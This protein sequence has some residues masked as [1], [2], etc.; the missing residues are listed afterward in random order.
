MA[1]ELK[2]LVFT[3][4]LVLVA[5]SVVAET[6]ERSQCLDFRSEIFVQREGAVVTHADVDA[7]LAARVPEEQLQVFLESPARVAE[8]LETLLSTYAMAERAKD[9]DVTE[10]SNV[11]AGLHMTVARELASIYRDQYLASNRLEDYADAAR[12][13]YLKDPEQFK[14]QETYNLHHILIEEAGDR[15]SPDKMKEALDVYERLATGADFEEVAEGLEGDNERAQDVVLNNVSPSE[16]VSPVRAV[17]AGAEEG[18]LIAPVRSQYGW[19][20]V[21]LQ[22]L[23]VPE[24]MSWEEARPRAIRLA[25]QRHERA[26]LER[27]RKEVQRE[28]SQIAEGAVAKLLGRFDVEWSEPID[29]DSIQAQ[30]RSN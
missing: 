5:Q 23:N 2:F 26:L 21:R 28:E 7:F 4:G 11:T 19:H 3:I 14:A 24:A 18:Q 16:L 20:V 13:L 29:Y 22:S 25:R 8:M 10:D 6:V 1:R 30:M 15:N 17:L 9:A 12:E 27:L